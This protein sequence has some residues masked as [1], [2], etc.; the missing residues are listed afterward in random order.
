[1]HDCSRVA[2]FQDSTLYI[3]FPVPVC[4]RQKSGAS[5]AK[6]LRPLS[7]RSGSSGRKRS[8][9]RCG[10]RPTKANPTLPQK[11]EKMRCGPTPKLSGQAQRA[12]SNS[13]RNYLVSI[14]F[15]TSQTLWVVD[16][17]VWAKISRKSENM[18]NYAMLANFSI[19]RPLLK[20]G[21][22]ESI[23]SFASIE[24]RYGFCR[25][26]FGPQPVRLRACCGLSSEL[27]K[28]RGLPWFVCLCGTGLSPDMQLQQRLRL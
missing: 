9:R 1:M 21:G 11:N 18:L 4:S 15:L 23:K 22:G 27:P 6:D 5:A 8:R 26:F 14:A 17:Y 13:P 2:F 16:G 24:P 10:P 28:S 7:G 19:Q 3:F 12:S 25:Q 20:R